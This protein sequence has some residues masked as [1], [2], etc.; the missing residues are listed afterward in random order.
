[1]KGCKIVKNT[2]HKTALPSA[3]ARAGPIRLMELIKQRQGRPPTA[4]DR[5]RPPATGAD[6]RRPVPTAADR[7]DDR[8]RPPGHVRC[9]IFQ[10]RPGALAVPPPHRQHRQVHFFQLVVPAPP[11]LYWWCQHRQARMSA[12]Q[13]GQ[14]VGGLAVGR[15]YHKKK[16]AVRHRQP[17]NH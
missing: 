15:L 10:G 7:S 13:Q 16:S 5:R 2:Y 8:R 12:G 9:L 14:G 1:M 3:W 4:F 17:L 11:I 6:R